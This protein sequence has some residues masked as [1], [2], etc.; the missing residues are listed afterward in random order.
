[1]PVDLAVWPAEAASVGTE[2]VALVVPAVAPPIGAAAATAPPERLVVVR[3]RSA[4][5]ALIEAES[6]GAPE[7]EVRLLEEAAIVAAISGVRA[8]L[9][10]G[11]PV[12]TAQ[13]EQFDRDRELMRRFPDD[14][15]GEAGEGWF[16]LPPQ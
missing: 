2:S 13:R 12:T 10:D 5:D 8:W 14:R 15:R 3:R 11:H 16:H 4:R 6:C 9:R 1:M 7:H